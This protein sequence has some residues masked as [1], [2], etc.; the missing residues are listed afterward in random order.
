MMP[1][2]NKCVSREDAQKKISNLKQSGKRVVFTNGCFD[3]LHPGHI[4]YLEAAKDLGDALVIG[5]NSDAS[6]KENKGPTRPINP[7]HTRAIMLAALA[8]VDMVVI[9]NEKTPILLLSELQPNLHIKGG[10]YK[11][12][13]LPETPTVEGYGGEI[14]IIPFLA[15]Y[16]STSLIEKIKAH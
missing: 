4:Q 1:S 10:D 8:C 15:G 14:Q 13:D 5:L 2:I 9:F 11:I 6:V 3:L 7:E 16:S 12:E